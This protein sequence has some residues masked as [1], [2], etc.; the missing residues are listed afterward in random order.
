MDI[1]TALSAY[2]IQKRDQELRARVE[3][4]AEKMRHSSL[5]ELDERQKLV[6]SRLSDMRVK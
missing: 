3:R 6:A 1:E 2:K 4:I 5:P